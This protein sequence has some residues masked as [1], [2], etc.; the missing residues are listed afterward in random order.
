MLVINAKKNDPEPLHRHVLHPTFE[1]FRGLVWQQDATGGHIAPTS[2][3]SLRGDHT[4]PFSIHMNMEDRK[5]KFMHISLH[6]KV[7]VC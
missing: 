5:R 4:I 6:Y 1:L 3:T 2:K 7:Q